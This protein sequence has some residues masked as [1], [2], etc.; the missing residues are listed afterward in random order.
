[1][2]GSPAGRALSCKRPVCAV[3]RRVLWFVVSPLWPRPARPPISPASRR[4]RTTRASLRSALHSR[5]E[6]WGKRKTR[7]AMR[8][9]RPR[10]LGAGETQEPQVR[11]SAGPCGGAGVFEVWAVA[12][13][14]GGLPHVRTRNGGI[15]NRPTLG[16]PSASRVWDGGPGQTHATREARSPRHR[17]IS[18]RPSS[19][20]RAGGRPSIRPGA[21]EYGPPSS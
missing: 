9:A 1:M 20:P 12:A 19:K 13:N 7:A 6:G 3:R 14:R 5:A 15:L 21:A 16:S 11:P 8:R 10:P 4:E 17:A 18:G 2:T